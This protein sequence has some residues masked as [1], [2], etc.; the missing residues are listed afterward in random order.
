MSCTDTQVI[1]HSVLSVW[2]VTTHECVSCELE[3]VVSCNKYVFV[4]HECIMF[5]IW[6]GTTQNRKSKL[7][8]L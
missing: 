7:L 5:T 8:I 3:N 1:T 2:E 4:P 6:T